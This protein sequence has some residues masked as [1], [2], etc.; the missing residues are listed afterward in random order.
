MKLFIIFISL[1]ASSL[2]SFADDRIKLLY[3]SGGEIYEESQ[4]IKFKWTKEDDTSHLDV[5]RWNANTGT[6]ST[7]GSNISQNDT[8]F[9]WTVPSQLLGDRFRFMIKSRTSDI[10]S[11][12]RGYISFIPNQQGTTSISDI[13]KSDLQISPLPFLNFINISNIS[14]DI[15]PYV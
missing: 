8:D 7:I 10:A 6:W 4:A 11:F 5:M 12:S 14:K 9:T 15:R 2:V 13:K 3:P 1:I